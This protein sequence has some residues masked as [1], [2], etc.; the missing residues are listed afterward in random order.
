TRQQQRHRAIAEL[1]PF[2]EQFT[3]KPG[4]ARPRSCYQAVKEDRAKSRMRRS[5]REPVSS[6]ERERQPGCARA[7]QDQPS[8]RR[9]QPPLH[10][11]ADTPEQ[12][13][14]LILRR[15]PATPVER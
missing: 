8:N 5:A 6:E 3:P 10:M 1:D 4:L 15:G 14:P 13:P 11:I 9:G 2:A 7:G 12:Q